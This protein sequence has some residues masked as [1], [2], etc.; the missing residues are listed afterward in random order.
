MQISPDI[1]NKVIIA[2]QGEIPLLFT[3]D[4]TLRSA[5]FQKI[6]LVPNIGKIRDTIWTEY[7]KHLPPLFP[8]EDEDR[9]QKEISEKIGKIVTVE[10]TLNNYADIRV[11][12]L[13][14]LQSIVNQI[15]TAI[16]NSKKIDEWKLKNERLKLECK[17]LTQK[18][19]NC[20]KEIKNYPISLATI[21]EELKT[22]DNKKQECKTITDHMHKYKIFTGKDSCPTCGQNIKDIQL[23]LKTLESAHEKVGYNRE[24]HEK[25]RQAE[26]GIMELE[27]NISRY[28]QLRDLQH[29]RDITNNKNAIK[30]LQNDQYKD[31]D[32]EAS[33]AAAEEAFKST[34]DQLNTKR[35]LE[36]NIN[37]LQTEIESLKKRIA[38]SDLNKAKNEKRNEFEKILLNLYDAFHATE[39][40]KKVIQKYATV[41]TDYMLGNLASFNIPYTVNIGDNFDVEVTDKNGRELPSV[42]GGQKIII[43][44]CLRLAL[45]QLFAQNFSFFIIDEATQTLDTTN[46]ELYFEL[47]KSLKKSQWK[48]IIL[49][50]HSERLGNCVDNVIDLGRD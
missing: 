25:Y 15:K 23:L 4:S 49:I 24:D 44:L 20:K 9:L 31:V 10:A 37:S 26:I 35:K 39:F 7:I 48:Q 11:D 32:L 27:H 40:T 3:G 5:I 12:T 16:N 34:Q 30:S 18:I 33:L 21:R 38:D 36:L 1:F 8:V 14:E 17:E 22:F 29:A 41:V 47:V 50:D 43:G 19:D 13:I 42:S 46:Q 6:F 2:K 45:L 28:T